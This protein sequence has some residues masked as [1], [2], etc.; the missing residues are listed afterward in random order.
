[1]TSLTAQNYDEL[2][3]QIT[4]YVYDKD[5]STAYNAFRMARRSILD[6][7]GC[8]SETMATCQDVHHLIGHYVPGTLVPNGFRLPG[9]SLILDPIKGAFDLSVLIRYLDHNDGFIGLEWGHPSGKQQSRITLTPPLTRCQDTLGGICAVADYISREDLKRVTIEDI[10][11]A[12]IKS[13]EIQG[14]LQLANSLNQR[15][16]DHVF[17]EQLACCAVICGPNLLNLPRE[18][19]L[20][21]LSFCILDNAPLRAYRHAPNTIPRKG[22]AA[23]SAVGR[24]VQLAFLARTGQPGA[25][26][27]LSTPRWGFEDVVMGPSRG[28]ERKSVGGIS[29]KLEIGGPEPAEF[30]TYVIQ[31]VFFKLMPCEGHSLTAVEA[32]VRIRKNMDERGLE[33]DVRNVAHVKVRT[34]NA[35]ILIIS[36]PSSLKLTNPADRD[37]CLEFLLAVT[38]LKGAPPEYRDYSDN[39]AW[40]RD[41]RVDSLRQKMVVVEDERFS[42]E[43]HDPESRSLAS[44][45]SIKF[46]D[47]SKTDE[48]VIE[49]P[50]GSAKHLDTPVAVR[51]KM[52]KNLR[53]TYDDHTIEKVVDM[54]ERGGNTPAIRLFDMLWKGNNSSSK[55]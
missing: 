14:R 35:A 34:H 43:Y 11:I 29:K 19:T 20:A 16:L 18:Q 39:A 48:V 41:E 26:T 15:G 13:Y 45:V 44:G 10:L 36:K 3:I 12:L 21:A 22:W 30:G 46:L 49:H 25:P 37:H 50:L 5:I 53:L 33:L 52:L 42:K 31:N 32:C 55:L 17:F 4:D 7:L 2:L 47:G 54:V 38:L 1:M 40:A 27:V 28:A 8:A 6:A 24:A 9:T 23:A 51:E